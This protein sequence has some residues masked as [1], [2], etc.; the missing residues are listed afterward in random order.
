MPELNKEEV[1]ITLNKLANDYLVYPDETK[2][3]DYA[4]ECVKER[5]VGKWIFGETMGHSWMKCSECCVSQ[6]GQ[7]ACFTYC[8]NCGAKMEGAEDGK[9]N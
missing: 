5:K 3:L 1:L 6:D 2:A 8:P 4:I 7:T 9:N